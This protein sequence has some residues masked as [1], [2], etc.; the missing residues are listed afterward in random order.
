[1]KQFTATFIIIVL[2]GIA[3][4][5]TYNYYMDWHLEEVE[6]A[7]QQVREEIRLRESL[8]VPREK[9][10]KALGK[11]PSA[12]PHENS[13]EEIERQVMS[14]FT[15]LDLQDYVKAYKLEKGTH[16]HF[17]LSVKKLS[18]N[19]PVIAGET[20]S[21]FTLLK[22]VSHLYRVMGKKHLFLVK[23]ILKNE[24]EIIESVASTFYLW[25]TMDR[26]SAEKKDGRPS[27][28]ILYKYSGFFL[29]TLAG[30]NY[31][32]RRAPKIRILTTYYCVLILDKANE[33]RM[34]PNGIDIRPHIKLLLNDIGSQ[35]G[36][37]NKYQ[38]LS[39]LDRLVKKYQL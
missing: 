35:S 22:N 11:E 34:N 12:V 38:Y 7:R 36:F 27:L 28:K 3:G 9:L 20:E 39:E 26:D 23:D 15:Y 14:F 21:L 8:P 17:Q 19:L 25:F 32:L 1:M 18:L 10:I 16:H 24:S 30:R 4:Y 29:N 13:F 37:I 6:I 5:F 2:L 31:L 33:A